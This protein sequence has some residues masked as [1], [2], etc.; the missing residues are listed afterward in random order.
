MLPNNKKIFRG[1]NWLK[2]NS[3][4]LWQDKLVPNENRQQL[5]G[6]MKGFHW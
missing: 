6:N 5:S 2:Q 1:Q 4:L 3:E